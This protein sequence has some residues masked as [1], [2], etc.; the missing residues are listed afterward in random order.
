MRNLL[1]LIAK[2]FIVGGTML[3]PG[4]SGGAMAIIL[5]VYDNLIQAA[6]SLTQNPKPHI[7]FL[8]IFSLSGIA[9]IFLAA[10]PLLHLIELYTQPALYFFLGAVFGSVPMLISRARRGRL[11]KVSLLWVLVGILI[12]FVIV[13]LSRQLGANPYFAVEGFLT[14]LIAGILSAAALILPGI[15]MSYLWLIFDMYDN[16]IRALSTFNLGYLIPL[17]LGGLIGILLCARFLEML[18]KRYPTPTY[19]VILGFLLASVAEVFPGLPSGWGWLICPLLFFI[20]MGI[21]L[22]ISKLGAK[23][24]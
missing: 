8:L 2:G 12:I 14:L 19:L 20:G 3:V 5:G 6:S 1:T 16:T 21:V 10:R 22:L 23:H 13:L 9:G 17:G 24:G 18:M 7:R 15:S 4:I 11:T